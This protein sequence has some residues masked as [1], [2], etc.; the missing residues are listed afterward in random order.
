MT[1]TDEQAV[2]TDEQAL[3]AQAA[4]GED[5]AFEELCR[6]H[7]TATWNVAHA[8]TR[9]SDEALTA[10]AAGV[11][12][13]FTAMRAGRLDTRTPFGTHLRAHTHHA[14]MDL[15]RARTDGEP[16]PSGAGTDPHLAAAFSGLPDRWRAPLWLRAVEE[17]DDA[18]V[19]AVTGLPAEDV[20]LLVTRAHHGLIERYL[21]TPAVGEPPRNCRRAVARLSGHLA[22]TLPDGDRDKLERHLSL[23]ESCTAMHARLATLDAALPLL[24]VPVPDD[25][26]D[27]MRAAWTAAV[28]TGRSSSG[29]SERAEKVLAVVSAFAAAVGVLGAALYAVQDD[30]APQPAASAPLAP[31]VD[32]VAT[33]RPFDLTGGI[34]LP[35]ASRT[36][37]GAGD[38]AGTAETAPEPAAEPAA[39]L[40]R[41]DSP[42][43]ATGPANPA[44][45]APESPIE[46]VTGPVEDLLD[47]SPVPVPDGLV[48]DT[49]VSL[50]IADQPIEVDLDDD[51]NLTVGPVSTGSDDSSDAGTA[52]EEED[53][54]AVDGPLEP[55][56][57]VVDSVNDGADTLGL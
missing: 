21:R 22:G 15:V 45:A 30:D 51:P 50:E 49:D 25:A 36:D 12:Q 56:D 29:M 48:P 55:A 1:H 41:T 18:T 33:P 23:C 39:P 53:T 44:P 6:R 17:A 31:L 16:A 54:V 9:R 24:A 4:E 52:A 26:R 38:T 3:A 46:D 27:R 5:A 10:L 8:V 57:P 11:G 28:A 40:P 35:I 47:Q 43:A 32:R 14:A 20:P 34:V 37:A 13:T 19:A 2:Q 7:T 42:V